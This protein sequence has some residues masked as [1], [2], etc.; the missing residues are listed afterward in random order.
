MGG[1]RKL[2]IR[3]GTLSITPNVGIK[4]IRPKTPLPDL[5]VVSGVDNY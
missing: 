3:G 4:G 1:K 5:V 2:A